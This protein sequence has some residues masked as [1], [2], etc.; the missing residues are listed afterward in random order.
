MTWFV[1]RTPGGALAMI[2]RDHM[3]GYNDE[4]LADSDPA[5]VAFLNPIVPDLQKFDAY[6]P[7][8]AF[9]LMELIADLLAK[10]TIAAT[11]FSPMTRTVYTRAKALLATATAQMQA[12]P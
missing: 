6:E 7:Y 9:L 4:Q 1:A 8:F 5:V 10:G 2:G 11:D 3:P 12:P